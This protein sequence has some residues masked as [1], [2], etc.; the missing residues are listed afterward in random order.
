VAKK[1]AAKTGK[2]KRSAVARSSVETRE[3]GPRAA[4]SPAQPSQ[5]I[6][7]VGYDLRLIIDPT[8]VGYKVE[9]TV[10]NEQHDGYSLDIRNSDDRPELVRKMI[11]RLAAWPDC[12]WYFTA[13]ERHEITDIF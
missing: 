13:N 5:M 2:P 8:A 12:E 11:C 9:L 1:K 4:I 7:C 6:K 10:F 3:A